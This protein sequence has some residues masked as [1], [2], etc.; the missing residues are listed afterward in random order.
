MTLSRLAWL[1]GTAILVLVTNV[2][3][4]F[5]YMVVYG[6]AINPGH[7]DQ[8]YRD[9]IE[10]AA[11]YVSIVAGIPLMFLAGW[12]VGGKWEREFAVKAGVTVWLVYAIIDLG[13]L[14]MAGLT[15]RIAVLFSVSFLTKLAAAYLGAKVAERRT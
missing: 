2:A 3:A 13:V 1:V 15:P 14:V 11:P 10:V 12:W 7:D 9:H 4:S 5:V 8:F 6:Y